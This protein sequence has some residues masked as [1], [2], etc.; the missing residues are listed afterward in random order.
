MRDTSKSLYVRATQVIPGGVNSPARAFGAVGGNPLFF[1]RG[2]GSRIT[3][4]DGNS[5][6]DYV[7]SWGPLILGHSNPR[8][9]E[10]LKRVIE[11]GTS[12]GAPTRVE[13]ELADL[14]CEMVP[15]IEMVRMVSSGTEATMSAVRLA[16]GH[17]GRTKVMKFE[18]CWHG[19]ADS[20]LIQAGSSAL[21]TGAP[22]SPGV[23]DGTASDTVTA[24][25]NDLETVEKVVQENKDELAA[26]I[27][28]PIAGNMGVI[29][30]SPGF[31]QGLRQMTS[32]LGIVLIFDEVIS[33]FRVAPGGAQELYGVTPDMTTLGK[34]IGGG[35]PVGAFGGKKEIMSDISPL[36][37]KVSQAG[38]LSGNP[39]A[40]TAGVE[41]LRALREPGVYDQLEASA[42]KLA[43]GWEAN[44]AST[45]LGYT[46]NRVGS[47]MTMFCS[48][49]EVTNFEAA[50]GADQDAFSRYFWGMLEGGV[51][52]APSAFEAAFVSTVHSGADIEQT[53]EAHG[54]ALAKV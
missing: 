39:L 48:Q 2:E 22:D 21:T 29:P 54:K 44:I 11:S 33:G 43:A 4:A 23:T 35:L 52:V 26:I 49:E 20:F 47:M 6:I 50:C 9:V 31:L 42:A 30:P 36:G 41:M 15:S 12:F 38:T 19:H 27:V 3:D 45:G 13:I 46:I 8:I 51:Y 32:D 16:R 34:I 14:V 5:Y 28:E 25:F 53:I 24:P 18:G 40:M 1:D 37:K 17:T 10:A 7:C